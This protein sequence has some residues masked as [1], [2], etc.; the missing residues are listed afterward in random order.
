MTAPLLARQLTPKQQ[1]V[2]GLIADG[3]TRSEIAILLRVGVTTIKTHTDAI[4]ERLGARNQ[5]HAV[6]IGF[7][8]KVIQ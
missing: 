8:S 3:F 4:F 5:A 7:R 2:L 1:E 6:A